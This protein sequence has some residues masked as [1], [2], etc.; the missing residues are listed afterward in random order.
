MSTTADPIAG[1]HVSLSANQSFPTMLISHTPSGSKSYFTT[2]NTFEKKFGY[3][4]AVRKGPFIFVS[5]TTSLD[6]ESGRIQHP[7]DAYQQALTAM[8]STVDAVQQLGGRRKDIVRVRMF[9]AVGREDCTHAIC[10]STDLFLG[11][12]K[13][14]LQKVKHSSTNSRARHVAMM[15]QRW[16]LR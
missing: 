12:R 3:H 14:L 15:A 11:V 2:P 6:P 1:L 4:R 16:Y 9:V 7:G 8:K 13:I 10:P 5:G